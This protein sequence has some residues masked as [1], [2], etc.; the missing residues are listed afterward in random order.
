MSRGTPGRVACLGVR[1]GV[2]LGVGAGPK[3]KSAWK[4]AISN[5]ME[6]VEFG[7]VYKVVNKRIYKI[8]YLLQEMAKCAIYHNN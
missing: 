7:C 2:G 5:R 4:C 8:I 1:V 3:A 6:F